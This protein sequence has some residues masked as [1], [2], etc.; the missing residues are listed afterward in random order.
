MPLKELNVSHCEVSYLSPLKGM[1]LE[2][3]DIF[4][5]KVADVAVLSGMPLR[6][7]RLS[8]TK[9]RD[10]A[11]L[12]EFTALET[13]TIPVDAFNVDALHHL[14]HLKKVGNSWNQLLSPADFWARY[15]AH[16]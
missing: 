1:M 12:A 3:I 11:M 4:L 7:L 6:S 9:V 16:K 14:P 13:L 15:D 5:T 10:V 8:D 2:N